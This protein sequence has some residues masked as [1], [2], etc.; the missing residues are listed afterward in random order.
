[1][2]EVSDTD[3]HILDV[4][5]GYGRITE[6]LFQYK[7]DLEIEGVELNK[8]FSDYF[9]RHYGSCFNGSIQEF[10]PKKKYDLIIICTMLMYLSNTE[11]IQVLDKL[12]KSLNQGGKIICIEPINN[13][14]IKTRKFINSKYLKPTG[15]KVIYYRE[16]QLDSLL[17]MSGSILSKKTNICLLPILNFPIIHRAV[18]R[19]K[20]STYKT[21]E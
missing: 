2:G 6:E 13:I 8:A 17:N 14:I 19:K 16:K 1:V 15:N 7:S 11:T 3:T 12:W 5:C 18:S 20:H 21:P 9:L 10:T 4:G